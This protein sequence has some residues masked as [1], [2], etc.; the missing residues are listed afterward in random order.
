[1]SVASSI[2]RRVHYGVVRAVA[3]I[4]ATRNTS[5]E[6]PL[7]A[8]TNVGLI[9]WSNYRFQRVCHGPVP[10]LSQR[11]RCQQLHFDLLRSRATG[12]IPYAL[13]A[14]RATC[15]SLLTAPETRELLGWKTPQT[16]L[17]SQSEFWFIPAQHRGI[18]L[19]ARPAIVWESLEIQRPLGEGF[20]S[21]TE[22]ALAEV[23]GVAA[24]PFR[25]AAP[26]QTD[27]ADL[28]AHTT[29]ILLGSEAR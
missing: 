9:E 7:I 20:L 21:C 14:P 3:P 19:L 29:R 25:I 8:E 17:I 24:I 15:V 28:L 5:I 18:A 23:P 26:Q 22:P 16:G 12:S 1:M 13:G 4:P 6:I 10:L 11:T 2:L 27:C